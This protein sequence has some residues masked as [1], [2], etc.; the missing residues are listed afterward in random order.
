MLINVQYFYIFTVLCDTIEWYGC[1][2]HMG[3]SAKNLPTEKPNWNNTIKSIASQHYHIPNQ[4]YIEIILDISLNATK[5]NIFEHYTEEPNESTN[6]YTYFRLFFCSFIY[7][8]NF[9]NRV[10]ARK[11]GSK[12]DNG[13]NP[14]NNSMK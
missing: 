3:E 9:T 7:T 14:N 5:Y 1:C 6:A 4:T 12:C 10:W 13:Q 8:E 11:S 2:I